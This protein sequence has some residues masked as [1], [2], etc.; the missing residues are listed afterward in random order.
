MATYV[1]PSHTA[2]KAAVRHP[3]VCRCVVG[4]GLLWHLRCCRASLADLNWIALSVRLPSQRLISALWL[5]ESS[6][7]FLI[8]VFF[9]DAENAVKIPTNEGL[10]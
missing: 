9:A 1:R 8:F 5:C 7:L 4:V 6:H 10:K 3:F 2:P